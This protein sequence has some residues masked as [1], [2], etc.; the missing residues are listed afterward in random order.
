MSLSF[1]KFAGKSV[2]VTGATGFTGRLVTRKLLESGASVRA[3]ARQSSKLGDLEGLDIEWFRGDVFDPETVGNA[4]KDVQYIFHLAAAFREEKPNDDVYRAIHVESTKLLAES[5]VGKENFECFVHVST[6][7]VHGHIEV[8]RADEEYRFA[9]GDGY[10]R[11]KLEAELWIREYADA[12]NLP[13]SVVRPGPI[14]GPG[15]MRLL[16]LF[17]MVSKGY[18]L[19]IGKGKGIYHLVHIEDLSNIILLAGITPAARSQVMIAANDDPISIQDMA[20]TI[21]EIINV[22]KLRT[23]RLPLF[24]FYLASDICKIIC[25]PLG[26]EPP[27]YRRR[28]DFYTKDRKFD[29]SKVKRLLDYEFTYDN[30][31]GIE[32]TANWYMQNDLLS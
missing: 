28:V 8:D 15:D 19:M 13:Y 14:F 23:I 27:I 17:R 7:G 5:V 12:N 18:L 24:P 3:I 4:A 25:T 10:Q 6:V 1:E 30:Q 21:A 20:K 9:P 29:N 2:L 31:R 32:D 11:T 26:I 16:K 22:K